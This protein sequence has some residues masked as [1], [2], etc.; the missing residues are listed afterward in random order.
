MGIVFIG[1]LSDWIGSGDVGIEVLDGAL[2][3]NGRV[4]GCGGDGVCT[5]D[6]RAAR[7]GFHDAVCADGKYAR[8]TAER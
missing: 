4:G 8:G 1:E 3:S 5:A 7:S 6:R 2:G